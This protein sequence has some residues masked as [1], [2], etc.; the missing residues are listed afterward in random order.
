VIPLGFVFL[1]L[2]L[3]ALVFA[4]AGRLLWFALILGAAGLI[5]FAYLWIELLREFYH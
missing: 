4:L 1:A 5:G 3:P 2:T